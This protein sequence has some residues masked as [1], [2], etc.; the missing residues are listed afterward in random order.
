MNDRRKKNF[1]TSPSRFII[2]AQNKTNYVRI[3]SSHSLRTMSISL[4]RK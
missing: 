1:I 3:L 4:T 2:A